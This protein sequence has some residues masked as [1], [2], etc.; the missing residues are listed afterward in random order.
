MWS[1]AATTA[2]NSFESWC[3]SV[4][5]NCSLP[6]KGE[7]LLLTVR[8]V[9]SHL[10]ATVICM[11]V[12]VFF[13][14]VVLRFSAWLELRSRRVQSVVGLVSLATLYLSVRYSPDAVTEM[15]MAFREDAVQPV[16]DAMADVLE[17]LKPVPVEVPLRRCF[18]I[19]RRW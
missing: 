2:T 13:V 15:L 6:Y 9:L 1:L 7:P 14:G 12:V 5:P 16:L 17:R 4:T 18:V 3:P 11:V 19:V 10:P 8:L